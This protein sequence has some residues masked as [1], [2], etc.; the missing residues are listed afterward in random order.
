MLSVIHLSASVELPATAPA[1]EPE[2]LARLALFK[3]VDVAR[4]APLV[5][6]CEVRTL[7]AGDSLISCGRPNE[8]LFLILSGRLSVRLGAPDSEPLAFIEEG[9][10]V[11][12]LSLI[13]HQPTS[14]S[15]IAEETTRALALDEE[16]VWILINSSHAVSSNLLYTLVKRMRNGNNMIFES[17]CRLE[18]YR[19][20]ATVDALT[21]LFNR[22]WLNQMLPRQ[23]HRSVSSA[24]P[25]SL[26]MLDIDLFKGYNDRHGH[27]AG[28]QVLATVAEAVR[29]S[30]RPGDMAARYGGEEILVILPG[31]GLVGAGVV[32]ERVRGA[33]EEIR[34]ELPGGGELPG[35]TASFGITEMEP[36]LSMAALINRCDEALYRAKG[37]GRNRV[38]E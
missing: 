29:A 23:M 9:D 17:R 7:A 31:C 21:G 13:D 20:H 36:G 35:V 8:Y 37:A 12:E 2:V 6:D 26:L 16:L 22:H 30:V 18:Q 19:F 27:L 1:V 28:D 32:A 14:A 38:S 34:V 24:E 5:R 3:G 10:S 33:I 25:L 11:G 15:V 4:I